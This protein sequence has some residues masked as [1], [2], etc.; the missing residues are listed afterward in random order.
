MKDISILGDEL[1]VFEKDTIN[2]NVKAPSKSLPT[3]E[4]KRKWAKKE[5]LK[6]NEIKIPY[7]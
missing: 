5:N 7:L 4:S 6:P 3:N 2:I 1:V